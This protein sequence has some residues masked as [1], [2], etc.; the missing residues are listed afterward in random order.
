M[1]EEALDQGG[2]LQ[3]RRGNYP[4]PNSATPKRGSPPRHSTPREA[5]VFTP[6][7]VGG[8][9]TTRT[10]LGPGGS[11]MHSNARASGQRASTTRPRA[12]S[13]GLTLPRPGEPGGMDDPLRQGLSGAGNRWYLRYLERGLKP[14]EA[15]RKAGEHKCKNVQPVAKAG[16]EETGG[17][18]RQLHQTS[19]Q[20]NP[21][22]VPKKPK[23]RGESHAEVGQAPSQS[24][25]RPRV[26][27]ASATKSV[28][29]GITATDYPSR[30]L[31]KEELT[32]VETMLIRELRKGWSTSLN[33][34][35]IRFRPGLIIV[36]C[37]DD[38]TRDW[39]LQELEVVSAHLPR[40]SGEEEQTS[41]DL[42]K[43]QN[44]DL[45]PDT[46]TV[47]KCTD[48]S[49]GKLV[50]LG[51]EQ[52]A[53]LLLQQ[54]GMLLSYRFGQL[55]CRLHKKKGAA[56]TATPTAGPS[57]E[58]AVPDAVNTAEREALAELEAEV[59]SA[60]LGGLDLEGLQVGESEDG[61]SEDEQTLVPDSLDD[62]LEL[63]EE[64]PVL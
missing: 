18:K 48:T 35:N 53:L 22:A 21:K 61:K 6:Q 9:T 25:K 55:P 32:S 59:D 23:G 38:N 39:L 4:P 43:R 44:S 3:P 14:E 47:L 54:N 31:A 46:W 57:T 1:E 15:R 56:A 34:N 40:S 50:T 64:E 33:F 17:R 30:L 52:P 60:S 51:V 45:L 29:V 10:T 42:L 13:K 49:G 27:Y 7:V 58:V 12:A 2:N 26:S 5:G 19:P 20:E 28:K 16:G 11:A 37:R 63:S 8:T 36:E 62:S 24:M 41:V